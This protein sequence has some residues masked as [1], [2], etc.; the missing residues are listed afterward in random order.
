MKLNQM[1]RCEL[2]NLLVENRM[3]SNQSCY[4]KLNRHTADA[5]FPSIALQWA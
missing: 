1:L 3:K 5:M 4:K 2:Q